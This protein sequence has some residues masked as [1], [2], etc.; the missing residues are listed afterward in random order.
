VIAT[1]VHITLHPLEPF[2]DLLIY[3][4]GQ[5]EYHG[6]EYTDTGL[7][8]YID[9]QDFDEQRLRHTLVA[10]DGK[11]EY[12]WELI[13]HPDINWNEKWE[14]DFKPVEIN[15]DIR[16]RAPFHDGDDSFRH[17]IVI[18][19]K[20]SFGTG[21]HATTL[22]MLQMMLH[23][24]FNGKKVL[25][26]G[27]GTGVLAIFAEQQGAEHCQ[28][29]DY[30]PWCYQNALENVQLNACAKIEVIEGDVNAIGNNVYDIILA[31]INRNI[32]M[33]DMATY[34]KAL[35]QGGSLLMSGFYLQD[36]QD[37]S[38]MAVSL[39][40][41]YRDHTHVDSWVCARFEKLMTNE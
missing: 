13:N 29:I 6:F 9:I 30:D 16:I 12:S 17:E 36:W 1:E 20:M 27:S 34:Q 3:Y 33:Q 39:K 35:N 4:L 26:M 14:S 23:V 24:N 31:N 37:I 41:I 18:M 2:R 28:A 21:H 10:L 22:Q 5:D 32:L 38:S 11:A 8:A 7:K 25:D 40:L 15:K 19:P